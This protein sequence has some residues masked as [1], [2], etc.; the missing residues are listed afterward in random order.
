MYT[1]VY[2]FFMYLHV[3]ACAYRVY[4]SV[5]ISVRMPSNTITY[6]CFHLFF[7][8]LSLLIKNSIKP[9][10]YNLTQGDDIPS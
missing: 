10:T 3:L 9:S 8:Q 7:Q 1:H 6:F 5:Y 2:T 4:I